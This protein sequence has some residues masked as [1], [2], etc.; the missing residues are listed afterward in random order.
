MHA[1][2]VSVEPESTDSTA[3]PGD[4]TFVTLRRI[5]GLSLFVVA[6]DV[7]V[8]DSSLG[9]FDACDEANQEDGV[10]IR[11]GRNDTSS[12]RVTLD[13]V[14][15]HDVDDHG[16]V[17]DDVPPP[18][19]GRHV[20]CIQILGGHDITVRNSRFYGCATSDILARPYID[21]LT[22][23]LIENNFFQ[24]V[25]NPGQTLSIGSG[26]GEDSCSGVV[27]RYNTSFDGAFN[28]GCNDN[29]VEV[30]GNIMST[31]ACNSVGFQWD[32]NVFPPGWSATCGT[33]ARSCMPT[34]AVADLSTADLHL[35]PTDDCAVDQGD[36]DRVIP[37]D[38]DGEARPRGAA[39][40]IGA[41]EAR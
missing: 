31:G 17:C 34:F 12:S 24:A 22:N 28:G 11:L 23:I 1:S 7:L 13:H 18:A 41:D 9:G 2:R 40:D 10:Q 4:V 35:S 6:N 33:N 5:V 8:A 37:T 32:H 3:G 15:V 38:I 36:P 27:I 19:R 29:P 30:Y 16:N 26:S 25:T 20:D 14:V 39:P 21:T